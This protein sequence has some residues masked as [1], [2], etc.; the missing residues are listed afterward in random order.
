MS[1]P[2]RKSWNLIRYALIGT[3]SISLLWLVLTYTLG[4]YTFRYYPHIAKIIPQAPIDISLERADELLALSK[5][6]PQSIPPLEIAE[7]RPATTLY[8]A[9]TLSPAEPDGSSVLHR[10]LAIELA[11]RVLATDPL[12][13]RGWQVLGSAAE[14]SGDRIRARQFMLRSA[15][16]SKHEKKAIA[17]LL[18]QSHEEKSYKTALSYFDILL[19]LQPN[20]LKQLMPILAGY[21][22]NKDTLDYLKSLLATNP[23]WR[24]DYLEALTSAGGDPRSP[25]ALLM[26][27]QS[28]PHPPS[29]SDIRTYTDFLIRKKYFELAYDA[30]LQL[31]PLDELPKI[32]LLYNGLFDHKPNGLAF[33][34]RFASGPGNAV[35]IVPMSD[36]STNG[37]L[38][39]QFGQG[40]L[41]FEPVEQMVL[42][43]PGRYVFS[44]NYRSEYTGRRGLSWRLWC[45]TGK[46]IGESQMFT[47]VTK[48]WRKFEFP[49]NVPSA[50]CPAQYIRLIFDSRSASEQFAS[51]TLWYHD[52]KLTRVTGK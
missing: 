45:P 33:D 27:L 46:L 43:S 35:E 8:H 1:Q 41:K 50:D 10:K 14:Q 16:L 36:T 34:W 44:G 23:P 38:M 30:W 21:S 22:E 25:L 3:L 5:R 2:L 12:N 29:V 40:R 52:I 9:Q 26:H 13:A 37:A 11:E 4:A 31:L 51:G 39:V 18:D 20:L 48:G 15:L 28:T 19:R 47:D 17:W 32:G 7:G 24:S 6:L 42:L 49:V